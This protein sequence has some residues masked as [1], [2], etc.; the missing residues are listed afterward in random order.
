[1]T[2]R[3]IL[4]CV[5]LFGASAFFAAP[6]V[7]GGCGIGSEYS[8]IDW[9]ET[10]HEQY[11][12][13]Y[14]AEYEE[15]VAFVERWVEHAWQLMLDKYGVARFADPR[16]N[17][18]LHLFVV[19][20]P[21]PN[22]HADTG[23]TRFMCCYDASGAYTSGR[24]ARIP[25]LTP[26]HP[27]W[28]RRPTWGALQFP[29]DGYHIKNII[30]EVTHAGQY[31][32]YGGKWPPP[33]PRWVSEGLAEYEGMFNASKENLDHADSALMRYVREQIPDRIFCCQ[34]LAADLPLLSTSD[35]YFGGS[36]ILKYLADRF[37][38]DIHNLLVRHTYPTFPEALTAEL[39]TARITMP[40]AFQGLQSWL[41]GGSLDVEKMARTFKLRFA[42]SAAGGGWMTDLVLL[43]P[44][45]NKAAEATIEIFSS[46]GTL[47]TEEQFDLGELRMAEWT[48]PEG[49]EVETGGVLVS[50]PEKLAGFL[51]FRGSDGSATSVQSAPAGSRFIVPVSSRVDRVGLA[52]Y[53][54]DNKNLT[55]TFRMGEREV[56]KAIPMQG[57]IAAFVDEYFPG[58]DEPTGALIVGTEP[59]GGQITVLAL[60][61]I[62][63]N[64][65][66]LPA[67]PLN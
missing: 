15:D 8:H 16:D 17:R 28:K 4:P 44:N 47:R 51:R 27:E 29:S 26:S 61:L 32:I 52:V 9:L 60:E 64:L 50:S 18:A 10:V 40:E 35:V 58:L 19:L 13:C 7:H 42:H 5:L 22:A 41:A 65:V 38:E 49:E 23:T 43:N 12:I 21:A 2:Y 11:S 53:N 39:E 55:V 36:L 34:T 1:M 31:S 14:T 25:Y 62:N 63:G 59:L 46:D 3:T 54:L 45:R 24:F 37:G 33:V 56:V 57:K 30:H 6:P 66:T 48:L 20:I 67:T